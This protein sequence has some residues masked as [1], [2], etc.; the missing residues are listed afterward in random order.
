[1]HD[2]N[3]SPNAGLPES[4]LLLATDDETGE[5]DTKS[6][7]LGYG[8]AGATLL[9]LLLRGKLDTSDDKLVISERTPTNHAALDH[10]LSRIEES[11]P[12][13]VK[14]WV[15]R[16]GRDHVQDLVLGELI[17]Q[18]VLRREEHRILWVIPHGRFPAID[19]TEERAVREAIRAAVVE[20]VTPEPGVS[21]L[22]G[23][24][25]ACKLTDHLFSKE[26]RKAYQARLDEIARGEAM[27]AEVSQVIAEM[28]AAIIAATTAAAITAATASSAA[29]AAHH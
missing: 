14:D 17:E 29:G 20:G 13:K 22:I 10:A 21:A 16:L 12:R 18:G 9:E 25:E 15:G 19:A 3:I 7:A 2:E 5:I 28:Q 11:K 4:L 8:L 6:G 26:E 27:A 24:L 1:M 23:L